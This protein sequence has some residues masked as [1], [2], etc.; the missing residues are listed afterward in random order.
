MYEGDYQFTREKVLELADMMF[1][2]LQKGIVDN[3]LTAALK[4]EKENID[5]K[6]IVEVKPGVIKTWLILLL[7]ETGDYLPSRELIRK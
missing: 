2:K 6:E 1:Y 4:L 7:V 5:S 3:A